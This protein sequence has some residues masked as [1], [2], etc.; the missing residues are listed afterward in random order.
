MWNSLKDVLL[1]KD[2]ESKINEK[3]I[4]FFIDQYF[5]QNFGNLVEEYEVVLKNNSIILKLFSQTP[6]VLKEIANRQTDIKDF[7]EDNL[8]TKFSLIEIRLF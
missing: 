8:K 2:R 3:D 1:K 6:V 5:C 4:K 7:V